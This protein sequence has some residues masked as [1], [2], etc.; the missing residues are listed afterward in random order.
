MQLETIIIQVISSAFAG[1]IS[2]A[3][4]WYF[5]RPQLEKRMANPPIVTDETNNDRQHFKRLAQERMIVFVDRLNPVNLLL[6]VQQSGISAK[7]LQSLLIRDI[8]EEY[9]HNI[10][11]QLYLS[12]KTWGV[13][14]TLKD[15]TIA[16]IT[17]AT[18]QLA[19]DATGTEM[20][21]TI[22]EHLATLS[23]SAYDLTI[24]LIK[25]DN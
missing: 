4:G 12:G 18:Q 11:Q 2:I 9:Q 23:D 6:R 21:Y 3:V 22:L 19:Q 16:M 8:R 7:E 15:D 1:V 25:A 20:S 17:H 5:I 13:I 14:R 10:A 24:E